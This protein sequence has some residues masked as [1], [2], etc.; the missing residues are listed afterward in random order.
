M[1]NNRW[2]RAERLRTPEERVK[3]VTVRVSLNAEELIKE[4]EELLAKEDVST[5]QPH[6]HSENCNEDN[7]EA[8]RPF[9]YELVKPIDNAKRT[10]R[11]EIKRV[12]NKVKEVFR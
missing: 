9:N 6:V 2:R 12:F 7:C 8:C 4:I 3:Q 11:S 5:E 1:T 10:V